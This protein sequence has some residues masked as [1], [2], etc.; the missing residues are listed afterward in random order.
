M[1]KFIKK[2]KNKEGINSIDNDKITKDIPKGY[3][4]SQVDPTITFTGNHIVIAYQCEKVLNPVSKSKP[5]KKT[6][7]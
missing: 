1:L 3:I 4:L 6:R 5:K 2:V 7:K